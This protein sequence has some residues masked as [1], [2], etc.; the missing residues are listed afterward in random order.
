[1]LAFVYIL[2]KLWYN[3][4]HTT[5]KW[6]RKMEN[7]KDNEA[8]IL[9]SLLQK[10]SPDK[11]PLYIAENKHDL[12]REIVRS[13]DVGYDVLK[14]IIKSQDV[15]ASI[16]ER[17][18][19][20]LVTKNEYKVLAS[21]MQDPEVDYI[22]KGEIYKCMYQMHRFDI[23]S[24]LGT[25]NAVF[26][27]RAFETEDWDW[28][29]RK[30][31]SLDIVTKVT[32]SYAAS[33]MPMPYSFVATTL[34]EFLF[35]MPNAFREVVLCD[36]L[37]SPLS[38]YL[39]V[40]DSCSDNKEIFVDQHLRN[41]PTGVSTYAAILVGKSLLDNN[42]MKIYFD[43]FDRGVN[44]AAF[45]HLAVEFIFSLDSLLNEYRVYSEASRLRNFYEMERNKEIKDFGGVEAYC[46]MY[47]I[48][49]SFCDEY[50]NSLA[51]ADATEPQETN[52]LLGTDRLP[53]IA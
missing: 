20:R 51:A 34:F 13:E 42:A 10:F 19:S 29:A 18:V 53:E 7:P 5:N 9:E 22:I 16:R 17:A 31:I 26:L 21:I 12:L 46:N 2:V 43:A 48:G 30:D 33:F 32:L 47:K 41:L 36:F 25:T 45:G 49:N 4:G 38:D 24:S 27:R 50:R 8:F 11:N 14:V 23:S 52:N 37:Y 28:S 40:P 6:L 1:M 15:G 39:T 44:V 35:G 3:T